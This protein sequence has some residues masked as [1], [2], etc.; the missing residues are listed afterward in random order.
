MTRILVLYYSSYGQAAA[1][2]RADV[3]G[4]GKELRMP[5]E[6]ELDMCRYQGEHVSK[7]TAQFVTGRGE[8]S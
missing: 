6:L 7:I 1:G 4:A 2:C 3:T 5:S 8:R